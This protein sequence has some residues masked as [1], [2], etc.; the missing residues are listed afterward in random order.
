MRELSKK[1]HRGYED[2]LKMEDEEGEKREEVEI[3][4][5]R[6]KKEYIGYLLFRRLYLVN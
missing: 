3:R 5:L 6:K 2:V 4:E 1:I